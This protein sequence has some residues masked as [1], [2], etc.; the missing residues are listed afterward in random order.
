M[1]TIPNQIAMHVESSE[2]ITKSNKELFFEAVKTGDYSLL[3]AV[4]SDVPNAPGVYCI[5]N[6]ESNRA[7]IG[8]SVSVRNRISTHLSELRAG[9]HA[10]AEMNMHFLADS[11]SFFY[12][13]VEGMKYE[14]IGPKSKNLLIF[15]AKVMLLAPKEGLYNNMIPVIAQGEGEFSTDA[16]TA[17]SVSEICRNIDMTADA[18]RANGLSFSDEMLIDDAIEFVRKRTVA[19]GRWTVEKAGK[20]IL[21]LAELERIKSESNVQVYWEVRQSHEKKEMR[22]RLNAMYIEMNGEIKSEVNGSEGPVGAKVQP[23]GTVNLVKIGLLD[24]AYTVN[25]AAA[26][27]GMWF[28]LNLIG[29]FFAVIYALL[30]FHALGMAKSNDTPESAKLGIQAVWAL[31]LVAAVFHFATVNYAIWHYNSLETSERL[32]FRIYENLQAPSIIAGVFAFVALIGGVYCVQMTLNITNEK[33]DQ[34]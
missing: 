24:I 31:E 33:K 3:N 30:S 16:V 12:F 17:I 6:K 8:S 4:S 10:C 5:F 15:E 18:I 2:T 28:F 26:C 29:G 32:P 25:V 14:H 20:S 34:Q 13:L 23:P 11:T 27:Y 1:G 21:Y 9:R 19:A 7:Y 22:E